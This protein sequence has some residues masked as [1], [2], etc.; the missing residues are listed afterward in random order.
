M[1]IKEEPVNKSEFKIVDLPTDDDFIQLS[2][3]EKSYPANKVAMAIVA[4]Q[5]Q[6]ADII[7]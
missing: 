3:K 6:L 7:V 2:G 4:K 5:I 1:A